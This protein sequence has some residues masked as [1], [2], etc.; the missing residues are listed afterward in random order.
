MKTCELAAYPDL[1]L[2][3][4][5]SG[6][7]RVPETMKLAPRIV[8]RGEPEIGVSTVLANQAMGAAS[9]GVEVI[10]STA[11]EPVGV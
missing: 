2:T 10:A 7:V 8:R 4:G 9:C 11:V 3:T 6:C 5:S 1:P